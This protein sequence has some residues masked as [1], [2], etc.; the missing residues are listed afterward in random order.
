[1]QEEP[2]ICFHPRTPEPTNRRAWAP[3]RERWWWGRDVF[4]VCAAMGSLTA[5]SGFDLEHTSVFVLLNPTVLGTS[6]L[7]GGATWLGGVLPGLAF[8]KRI[9]GGL[10]P[11][12]WLVGLG[13]FM[14]GVLMLV[15][16]ERARQ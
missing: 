10:A 4:V 8:P 6:A 13:G 2:K 11:R 15:F 5:V 14:S 1:M 12:P 16:L 3:G 7:C 9:S